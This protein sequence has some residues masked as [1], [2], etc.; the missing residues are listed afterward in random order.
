MNRFKTVSILAFALCTFAAGG[1]PA[2]T[3]DEEVRRVA[4]HYADLDLTSPIDEAVLQGRIERAAEYVC[5]PLTVRDLQSLSR[6][7]RCKVSSSWS[8][9]TAFSASAMRRLKSSAVAVDRSMARS[10]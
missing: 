6:F 8:V 3:P 4:V 7:N 10:G 9:Q 5:G 1:A 2:A